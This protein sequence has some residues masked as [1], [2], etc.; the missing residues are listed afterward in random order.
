MP[1]HPVC[2]SRSHPSFKR[3][4]QRNCPPLPVSGS[5]CPMKRLIPLLILA[6]TAV[7][8]AQRGANTLGDG[9]WTYTTSER[10]TKVKVSVV[11][12]GLS[13]CLLYTSPSPRDS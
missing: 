2:A 3:R 9:P 12:K 8:Y 1:D 10:A 6:I 11:T 13:H 7:C 4:G 5:L